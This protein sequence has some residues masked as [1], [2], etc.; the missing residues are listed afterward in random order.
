MFNNTDVTMGESTNEKFVKLFTRNNLLQSYVDRKKIHS[1]IDNKTIYTEN[2]NDVKNV[3]KVGDKSMKP[4][5]NTDNSNRDNIILNDKQNDINL[6]VRD[7]TISNI[8]LLCTLIFNL[9]LGW[10]LYL[11]IYILKISLSCNFLIFYCPLMATIGTYIM[12]KV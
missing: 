7:K 6:I 4:I 11:I 8:Y 5:G 3:Y 9:L 12:R 2:E 1:T 10:I